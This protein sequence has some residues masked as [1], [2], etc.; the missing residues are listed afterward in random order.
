MVLGVV[1]SLGQ[2]SIALSMSWIRGVRSRSGCP[3]MT[4]FTPPSR[5]LDG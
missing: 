5:T 1:T 4:Q 2:G 3:K